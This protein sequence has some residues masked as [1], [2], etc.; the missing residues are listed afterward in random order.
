MLYEEAALA[1]VELKIDTVGD[2]RAVTADE[3]RHALRIVQEAFT[4][5]LRHAKAK[6]V[7][8]TFY[9]SGEDLQIIIEDDGCGFDTD[10]NPPRGHFGLV[11]MKE[12]SERIGADFRIESCE[13][14]GTEVILRIPA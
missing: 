7:G 4:N 6:K 13:G 5:A 8:V 1:G 12:R 11:G 2:P 3:S 14:Y 10:K 9:Y